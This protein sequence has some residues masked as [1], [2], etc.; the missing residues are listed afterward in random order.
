M[1]RREE[2]TDKAWERIKPLL[3]TN[4]RRGDRGKIIAELLTVFLLTGAPWRDLPERYGP[5]QT[6]YDRF[7]RWRRDGTWDQLLKNV[8]T[9]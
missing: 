1:V 7:T 9:Y 4:D 2:L 6:Y 5:W 8:Q 3:P